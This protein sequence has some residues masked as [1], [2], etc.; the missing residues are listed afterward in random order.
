M[1]EWGLTSEPWVFV[2]DTEGKVRVGLEGITDA[3]ELSL[4]IGA[5]LN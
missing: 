1:A 5:V 4:Y 2:I 3:E